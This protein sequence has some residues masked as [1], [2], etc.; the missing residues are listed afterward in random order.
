MITNNLEEVV[1]QTNLLGDDA[2]R[3]KCPE[4]SEGRKKKSERTLS[5]T[6]KDNKYLYNCW[7][8]GISGSVGIHSTLTNFSKNSPSSSEKTKLIT[9]NWS[10]NLDTKVPQKVMDFLESRKLNWEVCKDLGIETATKGFNGSG[11]NQAIGFPYKKDGKVYAVKWRSV[12]A[13]SF[14]QDG[15][16]NTF[17][18]LDNVTIEDSILIV[19]GEFDVIAMT[20]AGVKTPCVSVPNGAPLKVSKNRIDPS[21]DRKFAYIWSAKDTLEK[22]NK[23][24]LAVDNDSAGIALGE[25]LARRIGKAKV[26]NV[27]FPEDCK[28]A[29]DVLIKYG[30][31]RLREVID[32]AK[33]FPIRGLHD[34]NFYNDRL[35]ELYEG[36]QFRGISTGFESLDRLFTLS[37][38]MLTTITGI[39]SSGK[40]QFCSQLMLNTAINEDWKWCVCSFENPVEILIATLA[41][42]YVGKSFFEAENR[43]NDSEREEA[44]KFINDHFVFIDHMG[45]ASAD[46]TSIIELAQ[47]SCMRMGIRGLLIDPFNFV[48]LPKGE[49]SETNQISK[50]LTELQLFAKSSDIH[51]LFCAHPHKMYPDSS[52]QTQIPTGHHISGSAS[53]FAKSDHGLTVDR[54]D[55]EGVTIMSWKCRFRWLGEQGMIKLGFDDKTGRY[56]EQSTFGMYDPMKPNIEGSIDEEEDDSWLDEL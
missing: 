16:A 52:G 37:T 40:S 22:C 43:M 47:S 46:M 45:G 23:V 25:E 33:P 19:E 6:Q 3:I 17:F 7:H 28:D 21:E 42:M 9:D 51:V 50:M 4:C 48:A 35:T 1:R 55:G 34:A 32:N 27:T 10:K 38:G 13:K 2:T 44:L 18:N 39:P 15:S 41:E 29:N 12:E 14:T 11:I 36:G 56:L 53:W 5:V 26:F 49:T 31:E 24:I 20:T 8:C 54:A 30:S